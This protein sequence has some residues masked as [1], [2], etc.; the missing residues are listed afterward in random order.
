MDRRLVGPVPYRGGD[1][2][3]ELGLFS[4]KEADLVLPFLQLLESMS[5]AAGVTFVSAAL[6]FAGPIAQGIGLLAGS[7]QNSILEV[8]LSTSYGQ[9]TTG[10]FAV[11]RAPKSALAIGHLRVDE[12]KKLVDD[13][14]GRPVA[15]YPYVVFSIE[16][17]TERDDW[18][19]IP[20]ISAAYNRLRNTVL[21]ARGKQEIDDAFTDFSLTMRCSPDLLSADA[22]SLVQKVQDE[23]Y[24]VC[25]TRGAGAGRA[26]SELRELK[27][28]DLYNKMQP[29]SLCGC[30]VLATDSSS[31]PLQRAPRSLIAR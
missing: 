30:S 15:D 23:T 14:T 3:V 27:E 2:D 17:S 4:I 11:I 29:V 31:I 24:S 22:K 12:D 19:E 8:G 18:F 20:D 9:L 7:D 13:L 26:G 10:Y 25:V 28:L 21:H 5:K 1:V 6:P 16:G